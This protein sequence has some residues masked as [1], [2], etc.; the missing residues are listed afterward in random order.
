MKHTKEQDQ[1]KV[2]SP[3]E[4]FAECPPFFYFDEKTP[5]HTKNIKSDP[6]DEDEYIDGVDE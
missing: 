4:G 2:K 5:I 6:D 1:K 3:P